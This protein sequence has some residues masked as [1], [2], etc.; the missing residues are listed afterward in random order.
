[1]Y[2][3]EE[4]SRKAQYAR[5]SVEGDDPA[6][7]GG[8]RV[9]RDSSG[10]EYYWHEKT[11]ETTY[12]P[13]SDVAAVSGPDREGW[14]PPLPLRRASLEV[15][16]ESGQTV[17]SA[18]LALQ[19]LE[20]EKE[21]MRLRGMLSEAQSAWER[22]VQLKHRSQSMVSQ[23][24][25]DPN[26]AKPARQP[27]D[28]A[29]A[30]AAAA[31]NRAASERFAR[32]IED[33]RQKARNSSQQ[34]A[35]DKLTRLAE[36]ALSRCGY[37]PE[38]MRIKLE[39]RQPPAP[40]G[41]PTADRARA[42][43]SSADA[44]GAEKQS[45]RPRKKAGQSSD[46]GAAPSA[47]ARG[48]VRG[49]VAKYLGSSGGGKP[50]EPDV[51]SYVRTVGGARGSRL[52]QFNH[53]AFVSLL[54]GG[55]LCV[56]DV[57]N[58]RV[59]MVAAPPKSGPIDVKRVL[60]TRNLGGRLLDTADRLCLGL[61]T[62][63]D[64]KSG[65][66]Y[67]VDSGVE[68]GAPAPGDRERATG[69]PRVRRLNLSSGEILKDRNSSGEA[70]LVQPQGIALSADGK[71]LCVSDASK[72]QVFVFEAPSLRFARTLGR[73]GSRKGELRSP[74]GVAIH[75]GCVYVADVYNHRISVFH[76][77]GG[78]GAPGL[79]DKTIRA[80]L[81]P[82]GFKRS[83]GL[84]GSDPGL[85]NFPRGVCITHDRLLVSEPQR[86]Q[87]L[88]LNGD[89]IQVL[90]IPG[91]A[92]LR[93]LCSD[94]W[95]V[96]V[97]DYEAHCVHVLKVD[98]TAF[99]KSGAPAESKPTEPGWS[100]ERLGAGVTLES[101]A[102]DKIRSFMAGRVVTFNGAG[103]SR[104]RNVMQAWS[105]DHTDDS[106]AEMN[107][108]AI[109]GI[110]GIL[111][112]Y[113]TLRCEVHGETGI[114]TSSPEPLARHLGLHAE[115]D[116]SDIMVALARFRAQACLDALVDEGVPEGQL[117]VSATGMG[118][119]VGVHF[120]PKGASAAAQP[121][122][123]AAFSAQP[124]S[125]DAFLQQRFGVAPAAKVATDGYE[126]D[127][128]EEASAA[129]AFI[130]SFGGGGGGGGGGGRASVADFA[131]YGSASPA[132]KS[133]AAHAGAAPRSLASQ[134]LEDNA[135][136]ASPPPPPRPLTASSQDLDSTRVSW[137]SPVARGRP[138]YSSGGNASAAD[139][140][141][142]AGSK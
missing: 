124:T 74:D 112:Q 117:F 92:T 111:K 54:P 30:A 71:T 47:P 113:P 44:G 41:S 77:D 55:D 19:V 97:A 46:A 93:G 114:A 4:K 107:R 27:D 142:Y 81:A 40:S 106:K 75:D 132:N 29:R 105:L 6:V 50:D 34:A 120:L 49:D 102:A 73:K 67:A 94:G 33:G 137:A 70:E 87:L 95:R 115:D 9:A 62:C 11:F 14:N 58:E 79:D 57:A 32:R 139:F 48:A 24:K 104:L 64:P 52:G 39:K 86:V 109:R 99:A 36:D 12:D 59:Q 35:V 82:G 23:H 38:V 56:S 15:A 28:P 37:A 130:S 22:G 140:L 122:S 110:A 123:T 125:T 88:E 26:L 17:D 138:N 3:Y 42:R 60:G 1:M 136:G 63:C 76:L 66:L 100:A 91:A 25:H 16:H 108:E 89:P 121:S 20:V 2:Y 131:A 119:D 116:V 128:E 72:H 127:F 141:S 61:A 53:P 51:L 118:G 43:P 80:V 98:A 84:L 135:R 83:I 96:Y 129:S 68:R 5:P 45:R 13:P 133:P 103:E 90:P 85:L 10:R 8:W 78:A 65:V 18:E 21:A 101:E 134:F 69:G 7:A 126:D 31:S